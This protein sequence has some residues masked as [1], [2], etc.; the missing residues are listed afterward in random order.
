MGVRRDRR[1]AKEWQEKAEA[2]KT[3]ALE[4]LNG[5][6]KSVTQ[7]NSGDPITVFEKQR[8][9]LSNLLDNKKFKTETSFNGKPVVRYIGYSLKE[10]GIHYLH[11]HKTDGTII[12]FTGQLG[13]STDEKEM[14]MIYE[15]Y[16]ATFLSRMEGYLSPDER[17]VQKKWME[18]DGGTYPDGR[19]LID[20]RIDYKGKYRRV[21]MGKTK[22]PNK[23]S[24]YLVQMAV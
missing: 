2:Y 8:P 1:L 21:T 12:K 16:Q 10:S 5:F 23:P 9:K 6:I 18:A 3:K 11:H 7:H 13:E 20:F 15:L 14:D 22:H 19:R 17:L 4:A 24:S